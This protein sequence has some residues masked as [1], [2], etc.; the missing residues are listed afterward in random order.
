M[1]GLNY[2]NKLGYK[3]VNKNDLIPMKAQMAFSKVG[4]E[5][6]A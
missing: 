5:A 6:T 4:G 2:L 3:F 1:D